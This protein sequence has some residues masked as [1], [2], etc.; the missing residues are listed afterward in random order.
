MY[1]Q[2]SQVATDAVGSIRTVASFCAEGKVLRLYHKKCKLPLQ[3]G[4]CQ[5][6]LSGFALGLSNFLFFATNGF[7]F[8]FGAKLVQ[9]GKTN[10]KEVFIVSHL[11]PC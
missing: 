3:K 5:G 10:F 6:L 9:D 8:W 11:I 2:A 4:I 1:E 7:C